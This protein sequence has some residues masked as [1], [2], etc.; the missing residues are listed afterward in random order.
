ML[1]AWDPSQ[2]EASSNGHGSNGAN[3]VTHTP[4]VSVAAEDLRR[5]LQERLPAQMIPSAYVILEEFPL[6]TSG[7]VDRRALPAPDELSIVNDDDRVL[8]RT[9][10]E[11]IVAGICAAVLRLD[12][13]GVT[14][15][16]FDL[17][18][19][20]LLA[21]QV[22]SRVR[23]TFH[24]ELS[25]RNLFLKPTVE[26]L[27]ENIEKSLKAG[28]QSILAR[29]ERASRDGDLPLSFSQQR[30]WFLDQMA[31]GTPYYNITARVRLE[32]ELNV[33]ALQQAF[34]EIVRRHEVLRTSFAKVDGRPVQVINAPAPVSLTIEE[35]SGDNTAERAAAAR[36]I[37]REDA[38]QAFD[39]SSGPLFRIR[40]LKLG[41]AE[42]IALLTMHHI[43][44]DGWSSSVLINELTALY[45][46]F[47]KNEPSP[48]KELPIQYVDYAVW[49]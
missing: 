19:H 12:S 32:G 24:V 17:G 34:S 38:E 37:A 25:L 43:I 7:K 29:I 27:A 21:A 45:S 28:E 14:A 2:R 44:S 16:F 41:D 48:F 30:L 18:G 31:G 47:L 9:P 6:L 33:E 11:E 26:G 10:V 49:Q 4:P 40:L 8:P 5:F 20:S 36:A 35:V 39:L 13:V 23:E 46:A 22:I 1:Y 3:P 15:N 42:H